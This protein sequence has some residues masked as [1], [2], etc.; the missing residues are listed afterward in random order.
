MSKKRTY[1]T[2]AFGWSDAWAIYSKAG[3]LQGEQPMTLVERL[4]QEATFG[5]GDSALLTEAAEAVER[6]EHQVNV[7]CEQMEALGDIN[8]AHVARDAALARV[9]E[10]ESITGIQNIKTSIGLDALDNA[11]AEERER[12]S[13]ALRYGEQV[14][15]ALVD[16]R[17]ELQVKVRRLE[18]ELNEYER[19]VP[20]LKDGP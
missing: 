14:I 12:S 15:A 8:V 17:D 16:E 11:R 19:G 18:D 6:L 13:D 3:K 7:V 9:A 10:L 1:V 2:L 5:S 20:L 4:R